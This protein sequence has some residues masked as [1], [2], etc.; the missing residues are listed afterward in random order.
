MSDIVVKKAIVT[1]IEHFSFNPPL[2]PNPPAGLLI[3]SEDG[4]PLPDEMI[5]IKGIGK[6]DPAIMA[7]KTQEFYDET[8]EI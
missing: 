4:S 2:P 6:K 8:P 5:L 1:G 3:R 7:K